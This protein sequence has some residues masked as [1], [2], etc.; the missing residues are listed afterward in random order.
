MR[1]KGI[2]LETATAMTAAA[3]T[4][5]AIKVRA[6]SADR[7]DFG[8]VCEKRCKRSSLYDTNS[9]LI[10]SF[11]SLLPGEGAREAVYRDV[12]AD[13]R[14]HEVP[15]HV[16]GAYGLLRF[17]LS[18]FALVGWLVRWFVGLNVAFLFLVLNA[19]S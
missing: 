9:F 10:F 4:A 2:E 6:L 16:H 14:A 17:S 5:T 19:A 8:I 1:E 3:A 15:V 7:A 11:S 13:R 12:L 18:L